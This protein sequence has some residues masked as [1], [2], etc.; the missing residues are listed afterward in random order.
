MKFKNLIFCILVFG[1]IPNVT[2]F[3]NREP[4]NSKG[5]AYILNENNQ[6]KNIFK[7]NLD[8]TK[9]QVSHNTLRPNSLVK[10]INLKTKESI[11]L[12]TISKIN[13]PEFYKIFITQP[14]ADKL[15]LDTK[16]P[17]VEVLELKKNK[18]F[19]A[20]KAKIFTEEKKI[21]NKAP[22]ASVQIS[23]ISKEKKQK[24]LNQEKIFILI[25][26]F[27]SLDTVKFLKQRINKEIT[28]YEVKKLKIVRRNNKQIDLI[29]GPY[30]TINLMKNDYILL[31][32]F[33]FE[34]LNITLN[35]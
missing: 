10:I 2:K 11:T 21:S 19:V 14:V 16:F 30:N 35:D 25:G 23:N 29:S 5:F 13:Y 20:K 4:F 33:G 26:T 8:N 18:S 17:L 9:M 6:E 24:K 7:V 32:K 3:E 34:E 15:K 31:K 12:N 22:V 27:Y 1:C 28:N